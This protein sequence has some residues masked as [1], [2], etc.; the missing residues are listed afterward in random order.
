MSLAFYQFPMCCHIHFSTCSRAALLLQE[1]GSREGF[2]HSLLEL[3][4]KRFKQLTQI[5]PAKEQ[6]GLQA[7]SHYYWRLPVGLCY[8]EV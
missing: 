6:K 8:L 1:D 2:R 5:T 4:A 3:S 7:S